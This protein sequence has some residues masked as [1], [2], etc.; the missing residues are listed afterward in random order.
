[1]RPPDPMLT[2]VSEVKRDVGQ[3]EASIAPEPEI[4]FAT[5]QI[6]PPVPPERGT[7]WSIVPTASMLPSTM[8]FPATVSLTA[9]PPMPEIFALL[10]P[11][12]CETQPMPGSNGSTIEP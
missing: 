12:V 5:I 7:F 11:S 1:M 8:R 10:L 2:P 6:D 9:P 4:W 3:A